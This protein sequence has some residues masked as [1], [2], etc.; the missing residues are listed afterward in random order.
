MDDLPTYGASDSLGVADH[1][2]EAL[3]RAWVSGIEGGNLTAVTSVYED[4]GFLCGEVFW[5]Q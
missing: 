5:G 4:E 1:T 3:A 2:P